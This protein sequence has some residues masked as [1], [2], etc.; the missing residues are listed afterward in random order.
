MTRA[1]NRLFADRQWN[2]KMTAALFLFALCDRLGFDPNFRPSEEAHTRWFIEIND[3]YD[4][5]KQS[6]KYIKIKS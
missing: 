1:L 5:A 2:K 6:L 4:K 3:F